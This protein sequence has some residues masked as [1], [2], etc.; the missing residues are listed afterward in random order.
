MYGYG[1]FAFMCTKQNKTKQKIAEGLIYLNCQRFMNEKKKNVYEERTIWEVT[2][3]HLE[4]SISI[5]EQL[6]EISATD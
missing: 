5:S 1:Y 6:L 4:I 3:S 2:K